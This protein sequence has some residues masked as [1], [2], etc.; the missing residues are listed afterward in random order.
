MVHGLPYPA[1]CSKI[2]LVTIISTHSNSVRIT[3][4]AHHNPRL[5]PVCYLP[6]SCCKLLSLFLSMRV[7]FN[8]QTKQ[9]T[10]TEA[11]P[12]TNPSI[13]PSVFI[14]TLFSPIKNERSNI[15]QPVLHLGSK[16]LSQTVLLTK[17]TFFGKFAHL[18]ISVNSNLHPPVFLIHRRNGL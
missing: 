13:L 14:F 17:F 10:I 2:S 5:V 11:E 1:G 6:F 12:T 4:P 16:E 9:I 15:K 8:S 3:F 18:L 7:R